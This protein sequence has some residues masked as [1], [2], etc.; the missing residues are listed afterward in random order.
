MRALTD[1]EKRTI[2]IGSVCIVAYLIVFGAVQLTRTLAR[3]KAEYQKLLSEAQALKSRMQVYEDRTL[4]IKKLMENFRFDPATL[5]RTTVV[6]RASAAIQKT[7]QGSGVMVGAVRESPGRTS[8]KELATIQLEANGAMPGLLR[9]VHQI[10]TIG[11]PVLIE[12]LQF[13][14]DPMRPGPSKMSLVISILDFEQ[15]K[16]EEVKNASS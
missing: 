7:A 15:W 5:S 12:S 11:F 6:A 4:V 10:E 14:S 2:Q 1:H 13:S 8:N 9:F 3:Q 16:K